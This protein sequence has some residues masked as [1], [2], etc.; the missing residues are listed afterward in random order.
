MFLI[1]NRKLYIRT[2]SGNRRVLLLRNV[3][4]NNKNMYASRDMEVTVGYDS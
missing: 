2:I 1:S 4:D 3:M